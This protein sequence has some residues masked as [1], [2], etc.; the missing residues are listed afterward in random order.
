M[1]A[2]VKEKRNPVCKKCKSRH[3]KVMRIALAL[4]GV[5]LG[6]EEIPWHE[7]SFKESKPKSRKLKS[8]VETEK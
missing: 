8:K 6:T 4:G 1:T 7:V 2:M 3:P 5:H